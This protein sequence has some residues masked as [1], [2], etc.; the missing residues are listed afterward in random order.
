MSGERRFVLFHYPRQLSTDLAVFVNPDLVRIV[1]PV[2]TSRSSGGAFIRFGPD[3]DYIRVEESVD[4]VLEAL[5][6]ALD[7]EPPGSST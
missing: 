7:V 5:G 4:Q 2:E 1:E 3:D 6:Q